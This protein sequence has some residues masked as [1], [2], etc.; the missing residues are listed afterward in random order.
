MNTTD[1]EYVEKMKKKDQTA[2]QCIMNDYHD[3]VSYVV[4]NILGQNIT[5]EDLEECISDVFYALWESANKYDLRRGSVKTWIVM[6]TRYKALDYRRKQ[7]KTVK[8][9]NIEDINELTDDANNVEEFILV[10]EL[11]DFVLKTIDNF[12]KTDKNIFY[13]RYFL[14]MNINEIMQIFDT[15]RESIDNRLWRC[16]KKLKE[17]LDNINDREGF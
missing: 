6:Y 13:Y 7:N 8:I 12:N 14:H 10:K 11:N 5:K 1:E 16:R 17:S 2:L 3:L 9:I 15:T 4:R